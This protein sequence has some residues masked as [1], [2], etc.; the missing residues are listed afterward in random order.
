VSAISEGFFFFLWRLLYPAKQSN[1]ADGTDYID[2][3]RIGFIA[4]DIQAPVSGA[5]LSHQ[6]LET[7]FHEFMTHLSSAAL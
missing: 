6:E 1:P 5:F 3:G 7:I 4:A 2:V